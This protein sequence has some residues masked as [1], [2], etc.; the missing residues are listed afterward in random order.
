MAEGANV[1]TKEVRLGGRS[2]PIF[3]F[4]VGGVVAG[5]LV[6]LPRLLGRGA[7]STAGG[8]GQAAPGGLV[9]EQATQ[10]IDALRKTFEERLAAGASALTAFQEQTAGA[11]GTLTTAQ[12][13]LKGNLAS[14]AAARQAAIASV[15]GQ[16]S[17]IQS[18]VAA[19][20]TQATALQSGAALTEQQITALKAQVTQLTGRV[21]QI[22]TQGARL[23]PA[24]IAQLYNA[25]TLAAMQ[26]EAVR[27]QAGGT[28]LTVL[29]SPEGLTWG[30]ATIA[31]N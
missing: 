7:T 12:A 2:I 31:F 27:Q 6:F 11:L 18:A 5:G 22:E 16:V 8:G 14:E 25:F 4:V 9:A 20:G 19:L 10:Q 29:R 13:Q 3:V 26:V 15:I 24:N 1:L 28:P 21:T 30:T 23:S 17:G